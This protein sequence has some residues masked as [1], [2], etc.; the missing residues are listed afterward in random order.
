MILEVER[1]ATS[2]SPRRRST[3]AAAN[4]SRVAS[5]RRQAGREVKL[6]YATQVEV[7]PPTIAVFGNH[8]GTRAGALHPLPAQRLPR[9]V[10]VHTAVRC[11]SLMR[12]KSAGLTC[13][14]RSDSCWRTARV[15]SRRRTWWSTCSRAWTCARWAPATSARRTSSHAWLESR[16]GGLLLDAL[17]GH[18]RSRCC[19]ALAAGAGRSG[20]R[21]WWGHRVR[22]RGHRRARAP[23]FLRGKGGGKGVATA[24]GCVRALAPC[25]RSAPRGF[26]AGW[27][28]AA[29]SRSA[30]SWRR[31]TLRSA[32]RSSGCAV[33]A[34]RTWRAWRWFVFYT[35]VRRDLAAHRANIGR[36]A[37]AR[38]PAHGA[39]AG[40]SGHS[41]F[42][43][44]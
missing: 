32:W 14:P 15:R 8:P 23:V 44:A 6:N 21:I 22:C 9:E 12:R 11:A 18:C 20:R 43:T 34:V 33:A 17:K 24:S 4:C 36:R 19:R 41:G 27:R 13:I 42:I 40:A 28:V 35:R 25:P 5:R 10:P 2:A 1:S 37:P 3:S 26:F 31:W 39:S 7:A 30:R 38:E 16:T 29:T